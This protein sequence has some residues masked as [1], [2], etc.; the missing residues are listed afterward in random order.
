MLDCKYDDNLFFTCSLIEFI[1]R[2]QKLSRSDVV[3]SLGPKLLMHIYDYADVLHCEI[4]EKVADEFIKI[5]KMK[6]GTFDNVADCLYT[7]PSYWDIGKVYSRL[8][9]DT[10]TIES[11]QNTNENIIEHLI[12]VYTSW[13]SESISNYNT[14]FFYQSREYIK[15]CYLENEILD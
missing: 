3:K 10:N 4:I 2:K 8:I 14:D 5:S 1:G 15:F 11:K 9:E 6:I 12:D 7:V 13:I